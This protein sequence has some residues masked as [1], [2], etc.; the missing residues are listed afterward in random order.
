MEFGENT[1]KSIDVFKIEIGY[2][3]FFFQ[4]LVMNQ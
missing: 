2:G 1:I 4:Y 3:N